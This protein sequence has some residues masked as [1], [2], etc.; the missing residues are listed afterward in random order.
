MLRVI[1]AILTLQATFSVHTEIVAVPVSVT[2]ADGHVVRGLLR[3]V[4]SVREDGKARP[5]ELFEQGDGPASI[6]VVADYSQSMRP[7]VAAMASG[8]ADLARTM[9]SGADFFV[10]PFNDELHAV[11][12]MLRTPDPKA[13][14]KFFSG[15]LPSGGT[16]LYDAVWA[17]LDALQRTPLEKRG[18]IVVSDGGD[19]ASRHTLDDVVALA[20]RSNA[21]IYAVVIARAPRDRSGEDV[22]RRLARESG[23][24]AT[25]AR[26]S[27]MGT[28]LTQFGADMRAQYLIGFVPGVGS[29]QTR[30]IEVTVTSPTPRALRVRARSSYSLD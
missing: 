21:V 19:N 29:K 11:S 17:G 15:T 16:A 7:D 12:R 4:F 24:L 26:P 8:I 14:E 9:S 30:R 5:I 25:V 3:D 10:L 22:L 13:I 23:G 1:A 28:V 27:E 6:G 20:R 2:D 18:L